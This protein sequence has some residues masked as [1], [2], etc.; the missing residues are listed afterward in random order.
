MPPGVYGV[1]LDFAAL[2]FSAPE[3]N[4]IQ[5]FLAGYTPDWLDAGESRRASFYH[6]SPGHYVFQ[7][8]AAN[9]DGV[10]NEQ[11]ASL[12]FTVLPHFWQTAWFRI[13]MALCLVGSGAALAW[14]ESHNRVRRA[15][16]REVHYLRA[17]HRIHL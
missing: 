8:R 1:H 14:R 5:Y 9:N 7:A 15:L 3:K 4:R 2:S 16:E 11:V 12:A 13:G 6:L 17:E 10:W